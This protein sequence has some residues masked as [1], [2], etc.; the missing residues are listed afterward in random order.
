MRLSGEFSAQSRHPTGAPS[1]PSRRNR[2][3]SILA[4][5]VPMRS[6]FR[7][8]CSGEP[9]RSLKLS[10]EALLI[11]VAMVALPVPAAYAQ[12]GAEAM[13]QPGRRAPGV[14]WRLSAS[15][16]PH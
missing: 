16:K 3:A 9:Q 6:L 10:I 14:T 7:H 5:E 13:A 11:G 15:I 2:K 8:I 12:S 4:L 1:M